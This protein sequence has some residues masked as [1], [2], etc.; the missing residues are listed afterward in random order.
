MNS[1]LS[2]QIILHILSNL[3]IIKSSFIDFNKSK[4]L[5][6]KEF[7]L[8]E[9]IDYEV[10]D[11]SIK[12]NI[13]GCQGLIHQQNIKILFTEVLNE[14]FITVSL[15]DNPSYGL[16][17]ILESDYDPCPLIGVTINNK[18]WI[19]CN[20]YLQAT[21]L[22]AMENIKE[23]GIAWNKCSDYSEQYELLLS[24]IK[25]Q[26]NIQGQNEG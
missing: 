3:S 18:D 8:K 25:F 4:S 6:S 20:I 19:E 11:K 24:F 26:D 14:Y 16:H 1:K 5:K 23:L 13:Y 10:D 12:S 7:L 15:K 2:E 9:T 22:A 21:F 17:L